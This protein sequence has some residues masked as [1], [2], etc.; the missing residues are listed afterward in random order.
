MDH[1]ERLGSTK[2]AIAYE[3]SGI[4][5]EN[6]P[7]DITPEIIVDHVSK[8]YNIPKEEIYG[9]KRRSDITNAR[10][11]AM[12]ITR[13]LTDISLQIIGDNFG[14]KNHSTVLHSIN[15]ISTKIDNDSKFSQTISEL[16]E[17][18]KKSF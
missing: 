15:Q 8:Y 2:D 17:N 4:I 14:G 13:E 16:I 11:V 18:I 9:I 5:K 7:S 3:K 6:V 12:Y 10:Q 1:T